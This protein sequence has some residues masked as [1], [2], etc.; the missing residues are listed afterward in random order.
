MDY[1]RWARVTRLT[2]LAGVGGV[3][4]LVVLPVALNA[5]TGGSAPRVLGPYAAWLWPALAALGV[6]AAVLAAWEPV[7]AR[8]VRRRPAHPANRV[9]VLDQV[10]RHVRDRVEGSLVAQVR[11]KLGVAPRVA[12]RLPVRARV[13][14]VVVGEP[15]AGKTTLLLELAGTLVARARKNPDRPVPVLLDLGRWRP[16]RDFGEWLVRELRARYR[17]GPRVARHWL[18]ER[19]FALLLDGLDE[20]PVRYRA[21]CLAWVTALD[22]PHVVLCCSTEDYER[23]PRYDVVR[24]EPLRRTDVLALITACEPRLDGLA[25]A[26]TKHPEVWDEVRTPLAFGLLALAYRTGRTEYRGLLDTYV[27]ESA[28]RGPEAPTRTLRAL[29]FLARIARREGDLAARHRL[30]G[31]LVWLDFVSPHAVWRLFRRAS[32]ASLAGASAALCLVVGARLGLVPAAVVATVGVAL[33]Q[34]RFV[35]RFP[36]THGK[37]WATTGFLLG[38]GVAGVAATLGAVLGDRLAR[39]PGPVTF[40]VTVV[41]AYAV[42][43]G[44]TRDRYWAAACALVPTGVMVWTGPVPAVAAGLG[45]GL[46][47]V[48]VG[49]LTGGLTRVWCDLGRTPGRGPRWLPVAGFAG[50]GLAALA[51]APWGPDAVAPVTGLLVGLAV[52]PL[53]A[54]SSALAE[55]LARPLTL[56][57]LPVRRRALLHTARDRVLLVDGTRFPHVLVRDHL[58][59]CDPEELGAHAARRRSR[60]RPTGYG[61]GA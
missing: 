8:L 6:M 36:G 61:R 40:A 21:E 16:E 15:G 47:G 51:G 44:L 38:F 57:D 1:R 43:R 25:E 45:I 22:V 17:I 13:P 14:L 49:L 3:A 41:V 4:V 34:G 7:A 55:V 18:R 26:L 11:L 33:N 58:A 39:W 35:E 56:H 24:V 42:A 59:D 27:V 60:F 5:A 9:A 29:R 54:R 23:L 30:P 48:V 28:A 52:T 12:P 31:R 2:A 10:D 37:R 32:P 53:A 19:R 20:V 50:A 46:S